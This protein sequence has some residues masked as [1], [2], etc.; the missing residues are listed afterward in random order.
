MVFTCYQRTLLH[1]FIKGETLENITKQYSGKA[2][3]NTIIFEVT[4]T[5][6]KNPDVIHSFQELVIPNF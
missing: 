1:P 2:S 5:I 3:K 6:L 4:S